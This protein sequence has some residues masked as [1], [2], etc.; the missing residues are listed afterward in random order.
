VSTTPQSYAQWGDD[1]L[2]WRYFGESY[3]GTFLEAGANDPKSLSQTYLLEQQGWSGVL[4]EPIP[5]CCEALRRER[6]RS[7]VFQN[8]LGAPGQ[9]GKLRLRIPDGTTELAHALPDGTANAD[10]AHAAE[11]GLRRAKPTARDEV[12]EAEFITLDEVLKQAG[13]TQLDFMSLDLEGFELPALQGLD[14]NRIKPRLII[15]EDRLENL[16]RHQFLRRQGY[17]LVKRNGSNN[18]YM[19]AGTPFRI[20]LGGRLKLAR[21]VYLSLP[22]RQ[23]RDAIR[24]VRPAREKAVIA[25][26]KG[27]LG[28]Q[29]F[30]YAAARALAWRT[31]RQLCLDTKRGFAADTYERAYRLDKFPINAQP[32]PEAWR[33]APS[34]R[35][36]RHK[37]I[38]AANK[39]LPRKQRSYVAQSWNLPA[40]QLTALKPRRQRVTLLGYWQDETFFSD[41]A[42]IIRREL[43]PPAGGELPLTGETV[44]VHVRRHRYPHPL[45]AEY[46]RAA[47]GH[48]LKH[49]REPQFVIF[50]DDMDWARQHLDF[51]SAP[52]AWV[53]GNDELTDLWLLT[54]CRHAIV[55]NSSFSWWGA[56]L[57]STGADRVLL[58]PAQPG[59]AIRPAKGWVSL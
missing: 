10:E 50:G 4:V 2:V 19:P 56:W 49:V 37:L 46:Y 43:T 22:V 32:M 7:R 3:K 11:V 36:P 17:R 21:K 40:T 51:G 55:A 15:I 9:R 28:N 52:V 31:G 5:R 27:G 38:R 14:F 1:L 57:G 25:I 53:T 18:W 59:Y 20:G 48:V 42:D 29:M 13:I 44:S 58:F 6:P 8:A 26:L 23:L 47:I 24:R 33:V 16:S 12:I 54:R 35:H 30:I 45:G 34:L 41:C 39:L